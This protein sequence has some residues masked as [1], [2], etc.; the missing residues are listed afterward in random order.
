MLTNYMR[1]WMMMKCNL[2]QVEKYD[3]EV[4]KFHIKEVDEKS[5]EL[6]VNTNCSCGGIFEYK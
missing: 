6:L 1:T 3:V 2:C 5:F 4:E